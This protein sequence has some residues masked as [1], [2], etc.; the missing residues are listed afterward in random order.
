M[1]DSVKARWNGQVA[2][3]IAVACIRQIIMAKSLQVAK[4]QLV[5]W[6]AQFKEFF[7]QQSYIL[8]II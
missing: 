2:W 8:Q 1:Q 7:K 6:F 3:L 5:P 4:A